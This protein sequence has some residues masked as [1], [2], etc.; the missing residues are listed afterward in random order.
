MTSKKHRTVA[1][2]VAV[3]LLLIAIVCYAA[4]PVTQPEHPVRLVYWTNAGKVLFNHELHTSDAG[5]G[6]SCFDCHHHPPDDDQALM[7]CSRCHP[8]KVKDDATPETCLDCHEA[9]EIEGTELPNKSDAFHGQCTGCHEQFGKGPPSG[10]ENCS[11]CH[12]M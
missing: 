6:L 10:S 5:Y 3:H 8:Q 11:K 12:V 2:A 9:D 7:A 4:F 1:Y